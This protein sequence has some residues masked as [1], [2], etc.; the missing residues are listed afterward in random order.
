M[1]VNLAAVIHYISYLESA[2][3]CVKVM[4]VIIITY[5]LMTSKDSIIWLDY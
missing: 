5:V 1:R 4:V 2:L 3:F